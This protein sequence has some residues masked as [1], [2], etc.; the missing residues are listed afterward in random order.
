MTDEGQ[1]TISMEDAVRILQIDNG[2]KT[3][4]LNVLQNFVSGVESSLASLKRDIAQIN[5]GISAR[6]AGSPQ[7]ETDVITEDEAEEDSD[8]SEKADE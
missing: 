1:T 3:A 2:D 5:A 8:E 4:Y 6:N 7:P